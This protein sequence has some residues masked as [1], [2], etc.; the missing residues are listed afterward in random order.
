MDPDFTYVEYVE[1]P[2]EEYNELIKAKYAL[3]L[4]GATR[5]SYGY[6]TAVIDAI[7]K[8]LGYQIKTD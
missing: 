6:T 1:I 3:Q 8:S 5:D 7:C 4:I 2:V